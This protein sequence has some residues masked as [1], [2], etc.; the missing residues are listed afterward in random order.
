MTRRSPSAARSTRLSGTIP[1][2]GAGTDVVLYP[3][4]RSGCPPGAATSSA[5]R[6]LNSWFMALPSPLNL[7]RTDA[8]DPQ[9]RAH[10]RHRRPASARLR[11][12]LG[13][14][15]RIGGSSHPNQRRRRRQRHPGHAGSA[16]AADA[17]GL[18]GGL[19]RAR[20]T[21]GPRA[22]AQPARAATTTPSSCRTRRWSP[23]AAASGA[24]TSGRSRP[25]APSARCELLRRH[26]LD[27]GPGAG[28]EPRLPLHRAA[29]ARRQRPLGGGRQPATPRTQPAARHVRDLQ[30]AV[31]LQGRAPVHRDGARRVRA[32]ARRSPWAR[33]TPTSATPCWPPRG[34]T[35]AADMS[36]RV[37]TL[38]YAALRRH[39]RTT[40]GTP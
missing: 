17:V 34:G 25:T 7:S 6:D 1:R 13:S 8:G 26:P 21:A 36:Q 35:H 16:T 29:A 9:R 38:P 39:R 33:R 10:L 18:D 3:Q 22:V 15:M 2:F 4:D 11:Q 40:F 27:P 31:L 28:R 5:R 19:R 12:R 23:S 24:T 14:V 20:R 30:A 32:T 37:V